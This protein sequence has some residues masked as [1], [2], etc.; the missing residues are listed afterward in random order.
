M[1]NNKQ[2]STYSREVFLSICLEM[3]CS[4]ETLI[5]YEGWSLTYHAKEWQILS[6]AFSISK[7]RARRNRSKCELLG[8]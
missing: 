3:L 4:P 8:N 1:H 7:R 6:L 5:C 2:K